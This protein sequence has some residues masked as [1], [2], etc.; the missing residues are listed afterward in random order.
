MEVKS[1]LRVNSGPFGQAS[2]AV[3][4]DASHAFPP[5]LLLYVGIEWM[6]FKAILLSALSR[7]AY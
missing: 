2:A 5:V 4:P 7:E 6:V 1:H 3:H